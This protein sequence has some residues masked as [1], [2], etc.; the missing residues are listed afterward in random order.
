MISFGAP[1]LANPDLPIRFARDAPV[2]TPD[3]ATFY[4][5]EEKG[6]YGLSGPGWTG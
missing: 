5:G 3:I 4:S 6:V 2:N 1:F